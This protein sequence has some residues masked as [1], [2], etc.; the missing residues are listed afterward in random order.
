M[1]PAGDLQSGPKKAMDDQ[2]LS[3]LGGFGA[4]AR[5]VRREMAP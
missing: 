3:N 1:A 4:L 2:I 5:L